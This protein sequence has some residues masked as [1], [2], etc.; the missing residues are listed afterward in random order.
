MNLIGVEMQKNPWY[1]E[2][3]GFSANV[4]KTKERNNDRR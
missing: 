1:T 2:R 4:Q 3:I